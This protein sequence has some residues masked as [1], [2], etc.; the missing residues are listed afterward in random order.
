MA[1]D[2]VNAEQAK[3]L[4]EDEG[5]TLL[6][7]RSVPEFNEAHPDGAYNVPYLHK[8]AHGMVPNEDF[9]KVVEAVFPDRSARLVTSCQMGG[10]SVRA[11]NDLQA[12]G[13]T[14]VK[15]LRGGFGGER[16]ASGAV[17][18]PGWQDS[19]LPVEEGDPGERGYRALHGSLTKGG[20]DAAAANVPD[21]AIRPMNRFAHSSKTVDCVKYGKVLPA[22]KRSPM[23]GPLGKR[24]KKEVSAAA[25]DLWVE[26]SK[27]IINEYRLNP[28]EAKSQEMLISQCEQFFFGEGS[29]LPPDFVP[30]S[31]GK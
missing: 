30:Q 17:V 27:M 16:D 11:A 14:N 24:L 20:G 19:S 2:R 9:A 12:M 8:T 23:G 13:Y 18:H 15:D 5:Y 10:R 3:K 1:L 26:H 29:Q 28:A 25:W 22:L 4:I 21:E 7:V 6:D 31:A